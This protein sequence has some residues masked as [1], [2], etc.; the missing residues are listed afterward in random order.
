MGNRWRIWVSWALRGAGL[1]LLAWFAIR[2][3]WTEVASTLLGLSWPW[4][5][6]TTGLTVASV[7]L[8]ALRLSVPLGN[9]STLRQ[10]WQSVC[11]GYFGSL[12]L[13][14][15]GGELLKVAALRRQS[16]VSLSRAGAA[17][18]MDRLFDLATLLALLVTVLGQGLIHGLRAGPVVFLAICASLLFALALFLM[19]SGNSLR[20]Q[21]L[22]WTARK[23]GRH[24][25]I[26]R[27]DEI[28]DQ[29]LSL[30]NPSILLRIGLLQT[31]ILAVDVLAAWACLLAFPFGHGLPASAPLRLAFF[32]M[33]AFGIPLLPGGFGSHQAASI[34]ALAMFGIGVPQ[35]L[36][37]S[38]AGEATH[39]ATLTGLGLAAM[40]GSGLNPFRLGHRADVINSPFP[41]EEP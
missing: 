11:L 37:V 15:G 16:G 39:V 38:L 30:R 14:L 35:A 21:V 8:R 20:A 4:L 31:C 25:W 18:T 29:T 3:S 40:F 27:F 33:V 28:H 24:V 10:T 26:E 22:K 2:V 9:R 19:V 23:P 13:P 34:I 41:P 1:G 12:F 17:L 32:T 5:I 36:S 6:A 7:S